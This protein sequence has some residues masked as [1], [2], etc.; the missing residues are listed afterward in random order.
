VRRDEG[1]HRGIA[2]R[3]QCRIE[4]FCRTG[5]RERP[6]QGQR[7]RLGSDRARV[8][9]RVKNQTLIIKAEPVACRTAPAV[10]S[11]ARGSAGARGPRA[12]WRR[13][14]SVRQQAN[15]AASKQGSVIC[16]PTPRVL[17]PCVVLCSSRHP[18][19][20]AQEPPPPDLS[21]DGGVREHHGG[22][23][24]P[25]AGANHPGQPHRQAR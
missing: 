7:V 23:R 13:Q 25:M 15:P 24:D 8:T 11:L 14:R 6:G 10:P 21:S 3:V 17:L 9:P 19:T 22:V 5:T 12:S 2:I 4:Q 1:R 16:E 18:L 20:L